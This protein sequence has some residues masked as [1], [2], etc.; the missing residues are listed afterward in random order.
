MP[1]K[2]FARTAG[3]KEAHRIP[4][5]IGSASPASE[6]QDLFG[7]GTDDEKI[8]SK[9]QQIAETARLKFWLLGC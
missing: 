3:N 8:D 5:K 9:L 4:G 7:H 6:D 1:G 2:I